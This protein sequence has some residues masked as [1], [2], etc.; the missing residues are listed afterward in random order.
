MLSEDEKKKFYNYIKHNDIPII[1]FPYGIILTKIDVARNYSKS[2]V[3][4]LFI[5]AGQSCIRDNEDIQ[6]DNL[7]VELIEV[8]CLHSPQAFD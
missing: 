7:L 5:P 1:E 8:L 4:R 3:Y 6:V 2:P